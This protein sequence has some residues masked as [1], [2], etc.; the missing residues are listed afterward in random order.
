M[1]KTWGLLL[2]IF[3]LLAGGLYLGRHALK[4]IL[5]G[6]PATGNLVFAVTDPAPS[7]FP[8]EAQ[9]KDHKMTPI[10]T[11]GKGQVNGPQTVTALTLTITKVEVHFATNETTAS[12]EVS[13]AYPKR[14]ISNVG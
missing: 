4:N 7:T 1:N 13:L 8:T 12:P 14:C 11:P 6:T 5:S 10:V 9:G 3:V 2:V